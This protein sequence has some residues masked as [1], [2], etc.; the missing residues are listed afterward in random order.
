MNE[1]EVQETLKSCDAMFEGHVVFTKKE[2]PAGSGNWVYRHGDTYVNKDEAFWLP[3]HL[4]QLS[5]ETADRLVGKRIDVIVG[6][7]K[8]AIGFA[9]MVAV[10]LTWKQ[11]QKLLP[12]WGEVAACY[13]EKEG[14][15]KMVIKRVFSGHIEDYP[16]CR[17]WI[18]ED[19][20]NSGSSARKSVRAA[21][22]CGAE[23]VGVS[24]IAARRILTSDDMDGVPV[25]WLTLV[26][27]E[28][29][30]EEDCP[31]CKKN[32]VK[33]VSTSVGKG[34]DFLKRIGSA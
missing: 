10:N 20:G 14:E 7:E 15:E 17:V 3:S 18:A 5:V 27:G 28:M 30:P 29:W 24:F 26:E 34:A 12:P 1:A 2:I 11:D 31:L 13:S 8:G 19:I 9:P 25:E 33:S 21:R 6:P 4:W 16:G 32:G 23:V 22:A